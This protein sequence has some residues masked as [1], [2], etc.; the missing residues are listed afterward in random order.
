M[1]YSKFFVLAV[2]GLL[3]CSSAFA[4]DPTTVGEMVTSI[5]TELKTTLLSVGGALATLVA[6]AIGIGVGLR[7]IR[8]V[9]KV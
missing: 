8:K 1:R 3:V 9:A 7:L 6:L 2:L 5:G 4:V